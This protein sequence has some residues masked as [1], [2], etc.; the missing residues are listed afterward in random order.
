MATKAVSGTTEGAAHLVISPDYKPGKAVGI[1]A[2]GEYLNLVA[3]SFAPTPE[4]TEAALSSSVRA[5]I[6]LTASA[7]EVNTIL[8]TARFARAQAS[9][10]TPIV[11]ADDLAPSTSWRRDHTSITREYRIWFVP[12][13]SA[14]PNRGWNYSKP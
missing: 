4:L 7:S 1:D 8:G 2:D 13:R 10:T 9:A 3:G 11:N 6:S 14:T 12:K 5:G